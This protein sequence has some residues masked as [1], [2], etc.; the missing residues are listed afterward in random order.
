MRAGT[1][2]ASGLDVH[3]MVPNPREG[4]VLVAD[5]PL[6]LSDL[7][8]YL[9]GAGLSAVAAVRSLAGVEGVIGAAG[10]MVLF[11]DAFPA[12]AVDALMARLRPQPRRLLVVVVTGAPRRFAVDARDGDFTWVV[13]P[14]PSFG[15]S[16]IDA[17]R[18]GGAR[19]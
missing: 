8:T 14:R 16:I 19:P 13:L 3:E 5:D 7:R 2:L 1:A 17:I 18:A 4:V 10:A 15:W 6:T 11:P 12:E 9:V